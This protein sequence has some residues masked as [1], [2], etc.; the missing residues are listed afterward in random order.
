MS[1][2]AQT[3]SWQP[4][5]WKPLFSFYLPSATAPSCPGALR[6]DRCSANSQE[7]QTVVCLFVLTRRLGEKSKIPSSNFMSLDPG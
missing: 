1:P 7:A 3:H 6:A 2:Q 5:L 4:C